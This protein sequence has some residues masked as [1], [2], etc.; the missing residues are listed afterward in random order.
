MNASSRRTNKHWLF[1]YQREWQRAIIGARPRDDEGSDRW[2]PFSG[3][4]NCSNRRDMRNHISFITKDH[5]NP[6]DDLIAAGAE[7]AGSL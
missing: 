5:C 1:D 4:A 2:R 6:S 7:G 3:L